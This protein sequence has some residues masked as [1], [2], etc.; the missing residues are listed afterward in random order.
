MLRLC[1]LVGP[2]TC[3]SL[4]HNALRPALAAGLFSALAVAQP[5]PE[6]R[7]IVVDQHGAAIAGA[8]LSVTTETEKLEIRS[9][10]D[11]RFRAA[12]AG[13]PATIVVRV[14]GFAE[15]QREVT[16]SDLG[17][18]LRLALAP[19][20]AVQQVT[21]TAT[22]SE[23][24]IGESS[25]SVT[26]LDDASLATSAA[27]LLDDA[28]RQLTGF[29][30]FRRTTS[31]TANP[32][33]QGTSLRGV[34]S[35]GASRALV[36]ADGIPLNDPF[37][38][39]V[40]WDRVPLAAI[41]RVDM[42]RGGASDLYG[43]SALSGVIDLQRESRTQRSGS[44]IANYGA[45]Q[46][47]QL[48]ASGNLMLH[49]WSL[50]AAGESFRTDGYVLVPP[51]ERGRVN[52]AAN[53]AHHV[54]ELGV[55]HHVAGSSAFA[56][57]SVF[58]ETR[59]NG[60]PLQVN[61]TSIAELDAGGDW[62]SHQ[63]G[64]FSLRLF[65]SGQGYRQT[66]SAV[67]ADRNSEQLTRVQQ[68]PAQQGGLAATWRR[69]FG[70]ANSVIAGVDARDVRGHSDE[71]GFPASFTPNSRTD[72]GGRQTTVGVFT[73]DV[74]RVG[75][76]LLINAS[77]RFDRWTNYDA[78]RT[79]RPLPAAAPITRTNFP[80]RDETAFSPRLGALFHVTRAV[81]LT[82][83][84]YRSF[85]PP[86]LNELYRA[87]RV[88]NVQTAANENLRAER[89]RG[90]EGGVQIRLDGNSL[91]TTFF[92]ATIGDPVANVTLSATPALIT[93][94]RQ[95]LGK[96]RS[97]GVDVDFTS[98]AFHDWQL[99]AGYE[100][101]AAEV[102]S[103]P[104]DRT[105]EGRAVP[106]VPRHQFTMQVR[107]QNPRLMTFSLQARASGRQFDDD[108]NQFPL[109]GF[110]VADVYAARSL[111]RHAEL[112]VAVENLTGRRFAVARTPTT[113]LGP[114]TLARGGVRLTFGPR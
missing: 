37:G 99:T 87:F 10:S 28:L 1:E 101:A 74:L 27:P 39:W 12:L 64:A 105:L 111:R 100:F 86:T 72:A 50:S 62:S 90:G 18:G 71:L 47:P 11:G 44:V 41:T 68:A 20:T 48:S 3:A 33:T 2:A 84:A 78:A 79:S 15:L 56:R 17:A 59:N 58:R 73:G 9:D 91:R 22:R 70:S 8:S 31:R 92:S 26:V 55:A 69:T 109:G 57:G 60:T 4:C 30:T 102:S 65:G 114:P 23:L 36:L 49:D 61:S 35:S 67:A 43:A 83:A 77:G 94:Q 82:G 104:A 16:A 112:F 85:R 88:G 103:F 75:S 95:N 113:S 14:A 25:A 89:L 24:P 45:Q 29:S 76:R 6:L 5:A 97:R 96:T 54:A 108:L 7:G 38:G 52:T 107:Y 98:R 81:S 106:Q 80:D 110:L 40:Y 51:G 93:R 63:A 34:G 21:V 13:L 46:T 66:F 19:A 53:S 42:L 32:T